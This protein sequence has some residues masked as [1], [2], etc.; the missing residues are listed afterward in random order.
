MQA[1]KH[2]P[3][4]NENEENKAVQ[5]SGKT[6]QEAIEQGLAQLDLTQDQVDVE[7][8]QEGSRGIFGFGAEEAVV[9]LTTKIA[10]VVGVDEAETASDDANNSAHLSAVEI[11]SEGTSSQAND[12]DNREVLSN[13]SNDEGQISDVLGID[14]D[15][16]DRAK[17]VLKTLLQKMAIEAEVQARVG[18]DLVEADEDPP[19]ALDITG[20]DLGVLIGRRGETLNS[21]QFVL[22][23]ILSKEVEQWVPVVIDVESYLVRRRKSLKQLADRMANKVAT[24]QRKVTMEPMSA[25][26]RRIVHMQ[27]RNHAD[28]FTQ[29]VGE[30]ERRKIVI[31]PKRP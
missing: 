26:E 10:A 7:I 3:N 29:S 24:S 22:R 1:A 5:V 11:V 28:V 14:V 19:L 4:G 20:R 30:N 8:I 18:Y 9:K 15:T 17:E 23:Q 25:H 27:L 21:L 6:V 13:D 12:L 31:F 16:Q 2:D